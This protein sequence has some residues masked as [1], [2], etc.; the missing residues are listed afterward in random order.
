MLKAIV[1]D[2]Y[3]VLLFAKGDKR[4]RGSF[5]DIY[6][7]NKKDA[8]FVIGDFYE[9]NSQLL[10]LI[11]GN[12]KQYDFYLYTAGS[13]HTISEFKQLLSQYFKEIWSI[14]GLGN[15]NDPASY[16]NLAAKVGLK[17]SEILFVDD[18]H[19]NVEAAEKAGLMGIVYTDNDSLLQ[20]L[21][22]TVQIDFSA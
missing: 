13:M 1:F 21:K 19:V 8:D 11:K 6:Y 12:S 2:L 18:S 15:K 22:R 16:I 20:E 7:Q 4:Y 5:S 17:P 10:D 14:D 3:H 9:L